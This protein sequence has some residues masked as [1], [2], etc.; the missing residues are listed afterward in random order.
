MDN[1]KKIIGIISSQ[2]FYTLKWNPD[3]AQLSRFEGDEQLSATEVDNIRALFSEAA[4]ATKRSA[5]TEKPGRQSKPVSRGEA[6][7]PR[8][9]ILSMDL[10][11]KVVRSFFDDSVLDKNQIESINHLLQKR[12]AYFPYRITENSQLAVRKSKTEKEIE[13]R[14]NVSTMSSFEE[15]VDATKLGDNISFISSDYKTLESI[16]EYLNLGEEDVLADLGCGKGRV[17]CAAAALLNIKKAIGVEVHPELVRVAKR[18]AKL[19]NPQNCPIEIVL[20]DIATFNSHDVT[21]Y[22]LF[23]PFR[24]KTTKA[25]CENV[26]RSLERKPRK[27]KIVWYAPSQ[28]VIQFLQGKSW[29]ETMFK[30]PGRPVFVWEN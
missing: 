8:S 1:N 24:L 11:T 30:M 12:H 16:F 25:L 4:E 22:F 9:Y 27:I 26:G 10:N 20:S 13:E 17:V 14:L 15:S 7:L 3:T 18:N 28:P 6:R 5:P 2:S 21:A 19:M 23:G 29:L